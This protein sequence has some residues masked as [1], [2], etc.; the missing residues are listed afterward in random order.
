VATWDEG[1]P[2]PADIVI[3]DE[4]DPSPGYAFLLAQLDS[5][6]GMPSPV[7]VIRA[8]AAPAY[9][10]LVNSQ[11]RDVIAKKGKGDLARLL[12]GSE[13]WDVRG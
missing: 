5:M 10:D 1:A 9:E 7:G 4:K 6:P 8:V 3:H 11:V 12:R 13:T 2:V